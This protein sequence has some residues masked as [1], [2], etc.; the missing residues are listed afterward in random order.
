MSARRLTA[1]RR[2]WLLALLLL[3]PLAAA[4]PG[5]A[6]A[7][8][9]FFPETGHTVQ[10]RFL[11]YW[12]AHGGLAQQGYPLSE[13]MREVSRPTA[14][15]TRCSISS[16]PSS[17]T[18]PRTRRPTRCCSACWAC[19]DYAAALPRRRAR[20]SNPAPRSPLLPGDRP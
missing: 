15:R 5:A 1:A 3:L 10:G 8:S 7:N 13:E 4:R 19:F 2:R 14:S 11:A 16:A 18:T 17:S 6:Q 9:R 12:E 20:A